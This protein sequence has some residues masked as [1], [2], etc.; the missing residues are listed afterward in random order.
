MCRHSKTAIRD[1]NGAI[2]CSRLAGAGGDGS[3][4][5]TPIHQEAKSSIPTGDRRMAFYDIAGAPTAVLR[6]DLM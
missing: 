5:D 1:K 4:Q 6:N 2:G 3:R